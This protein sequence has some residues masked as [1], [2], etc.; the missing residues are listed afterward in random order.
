[1]GGAGSY[2]PVTGEEHPRIDVKL[3]TA[4]PPEDCRR[5]NLG[6]VDPASLDVAALAGEEGTLVVPR[7]G[8]V[9]FRVKG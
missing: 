2:D 3:A 4:L 8:E 1:M 7:S 9:L 6:Y 5:L